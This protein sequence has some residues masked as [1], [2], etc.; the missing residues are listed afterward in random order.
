MNKKHGQILRCAVGGVLLGGALSA[1]LL[2]AGSPPSRQTPTIVS[3]EKKG[4]VAVPPGQLPPAVGGIPLAPSARTYGYHEPRWRPFPGQQRYDN[5]FTQAIGAEPVSP[6][7]RRK[8]EEPTPAAAGF[9]EEEFSLPTLPE[10]GGPKTLPPI[11]DGPVWPTEPKPTFPAPKQDFLESDKLFPEEPDFDS[12]GFLPVDF[13][14]KGNLPQND[15]IHTLNARGPEQVNQ[16]SYEGQKKMR[17][18]DVLD[19]LKSQEGTVEGGYG[20]SKPQS[21]DVTLPEMKPSESYEMSDPNQEMEFPPMETRRI[22]E[23][24][25]PENM[26]YG[27][28]VDSD[29]SM[30]Y[31][32]PR[33]NTDI[34][35]GQPPMALE[36]FCPVT[37]MHSETWVQGNPRYTVTYQG[38][39]YSLFSQANVQEFYSDP[40]KYTPIMEGCDPVIMSEQGRKVPGTPD[41]CIVYEGRLYMFATEDSMNRFYTHA[42]DFRDYALYAEKVMQ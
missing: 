29:F 40:R 5:Y 24:A 8:I 17:V 37:L 30:E 19:A 10:M 21:G 2:T 1:G 16:I 28:P 15:V 23:I 20:P 32:A 35:F 39:T 13:T 9:R 14:E 11:N 25:A 4:Q 33:R 34:P 36:G 18:S 27:R 26:R 22:P 3:S 41:F 6:S 7:A 42:D 12:P 38:K 31:T